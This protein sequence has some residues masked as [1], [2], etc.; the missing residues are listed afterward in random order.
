MPGRPTVRPLS[1]TTTSGRGLALVD[2]VA[3]DW[4]VD[5]NRAIHSDHGKVVWARISLDD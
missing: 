2:Q 1:P 4:G 5:T 3:D